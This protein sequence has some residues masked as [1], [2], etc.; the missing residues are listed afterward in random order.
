MKEYTS[1]YLS[2]IGRQLSNGKGQNHATVMH[3][4]KQVE[5]AYWSLITKAKSA[6]MIYIA[7]QRWQRTY[8]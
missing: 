8:F 2:E 4:I 7:C 3:S 6:T 1:Y 5:S